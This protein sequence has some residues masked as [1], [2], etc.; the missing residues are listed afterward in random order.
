MTNQHGARLDAMKP[1]RAGQAKS[2]NI[3]TASLPDHAL[4]R[5]AKKA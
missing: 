1:V 4:M 2:S 5:F 3:A